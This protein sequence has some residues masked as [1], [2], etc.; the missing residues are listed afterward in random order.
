[1]F[2]FRIEALGFYIAPHGIRCAAL[3]SRSLHHATG[4]LYQ[5]VLLLDRTCH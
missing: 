5:S 3:A 4:P 2:R 1:M